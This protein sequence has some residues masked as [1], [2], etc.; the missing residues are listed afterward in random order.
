MDPMTEHT[1]IRISPLMEDFPIVHI[2]KKAVWFRAGQQHRF[3]A[4]SFM[5]NISII[6][7]SIEESLA[8]DGT[9]I[10]SVPLPD[11]TLLPKYASPASE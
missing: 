6:G 9:F 11:C 10:L 7:D 3:L 4:T 5:Y 1:H 2:T 8:M